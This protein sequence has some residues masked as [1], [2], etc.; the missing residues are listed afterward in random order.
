VGAEERE[1]DF[2]EGRDREALV[3]ERVRAMRETVRCMVGFVMLLADGM[4]SWRRLGGLVVLSVY[5]IGDM[6]SVLMPCP[7]R[8]ITTFISTGYYSSDKGVSN[9]VTQISR[10][11]KSSHL[12]QYAGTLS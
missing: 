9:R 2:V 10:M 5:E 1:S 8:L 3:R 11:G 7:P 6:S 12:L 4:L